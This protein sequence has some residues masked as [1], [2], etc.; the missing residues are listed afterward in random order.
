MTKTTG[1]P[2]PEVK[3]ATR[4][5][6]LIG[7]ASLLVLAP[8]GCG[9][10]GGG[11]GGGAR[12]GGGR[13]VEHALGRA[14]LP[15]EPRRVVA[16]DSFIALPALL[17]AGVPVVGALSVSS[18]SGGGDLPS[19]VTPEEAE[20]IE[21]VGGAESGPNLEAIAALNPDAIVCWS[22]LTDEGL[23]ENLTRI[24]P[25]VLTEGSAYLGG[26]WREEARRI[27]SWF[28][29]RERMDERISSYEERVE[30]L[31]RRIEDRLGSP[32]VSAL[33]ITE[34]QLLLYYDCFWPGSVL[35]DAGLR[36]PENQLRED[37][38]P[39]F[40]E[41]HAETLSLEKLPEVDADAIF[42]Y[43]G[44]DPAGAEALMGRMTESPLWRSLDAVQNGRAYAVGGDAWLFANTR[45]ADLVLDDLQ[46]HLLGGGERT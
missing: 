4:R 36:R 16:L 1:I 38:C 19:Y 32:T 41:K 22:V 6:F 21:I 42:Y 12:G 9:G 24:A 33:R 29:A 27:S 30:G 7:A 34:D 13:T 25:T 23:Y 31:R 17:D 5:E 10:T 11:A 43:V 28:G 3:D 45:A 26:D 39:N 46:E 8:Y 15:A 40:Q 44:G 14:E 35:A 37:G 18:I 20:G 2:L